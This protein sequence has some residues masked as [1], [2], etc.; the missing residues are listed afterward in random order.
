VARA[1]RRWMREQGM[2]DPARLVFIDE[3]SA[4]TKMVRLY[5]RCARG[6]RL[7]GPVPLEDDHL[8]GRAASP[9]HE[10]PDCVQIDGQIRQPLSP[11]SD[12][13]G[14]AC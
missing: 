3:T 11:Q 9:W 5:G 13:V 14:A 12:I 2:F 7:V 6:E 4:N 10:R 1:R 8:C